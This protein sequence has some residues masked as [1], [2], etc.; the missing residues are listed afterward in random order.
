MIS[1]VLTGAKHTVLPASGLAEASEALCNQ[2]FDAV[3]VGSGL[4]GD[5]VS[6]MAEKLRSLERSQAGTSRTPILSVSPEVC[7]ASE[8]RGSEDGVIDGYLPECFEADALV[9]AVRSLGSVVSAASDSSRS[10]D[11][12]DLPVFEPDK[13]KEQVANDRNL[14]I[15]I[16]DL[17]LSEHPVQVADMREALVTADFDRVYL[18]AHTIKGS[19]ASLHA[20]VGRLRAE[21]LESAAKQRNGEECEHALA[22]LKRDLE[23][24]EPALLNLRDAPDAA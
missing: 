4:A 22:L 24:L 23:A 17:F 14:L 5:G 10:P 7:D 16:I 2:K 13:F 18:T 21:E 6:E 9:A 11:F 1:T 3:L 12:A 8:W 19:L 15:E 20:A